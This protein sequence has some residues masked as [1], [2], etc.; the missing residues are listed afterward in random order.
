MIPLDVKSF[1]K[2][3]TKLI[4]IHYSDKAKLQHLKS[5]ILHDTTCADRDWLIE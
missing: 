4:N 2:Y 3:M 5:E 1:Y